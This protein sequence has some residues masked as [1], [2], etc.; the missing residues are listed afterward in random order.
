M[1]KIVIIFLSIVTLSSGMI[2]GGCG[3]LNSRS[4]K[5]EILQISESKKMKKALK[6]LLRELDPKALTPEGKIKTYEIKKEM[7]EYN[8]MGGLNV[9]ITI[10]GDEKLYINM[11]VQEEEAG[12]Y[13]VVSYGV[14]QELSQL[15]GE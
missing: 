5:E 10:N 9:Y 1:K 7:L 14:S 13:E 4:E 12:N 11:T 15:I 6:I 2:L 3:M 8:P